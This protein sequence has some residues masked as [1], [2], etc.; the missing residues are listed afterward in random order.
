MIETVGSLILGIII[1]GVTLFKVV[2]KPNKEK[3]KEANN[4][5]SK[6]KAEIKTI[7]KANRVLKKSNLNAEESRRKV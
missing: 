5:L 2:I 1:A 4:E 3:L 7:N 6:S